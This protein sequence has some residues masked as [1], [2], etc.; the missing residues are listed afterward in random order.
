MQVCLSGPGLGDAGTLVQQ[1]DE[2][3]PVLSRRDV[4][5]LT[6]GEHGCEVQTDDEPAE[7]D[8]A[9]TP[10]KVLCTDMRLHMRLDMRLDV[11]LKKCPVCQRRSC[12]AHRWQRSVATVSGDSQR[13]QQVATVSGDGQES[14]RFRRKRRVV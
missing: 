14:V 4:I 8:A 5:T 7:A 11:C 10:T 3:T 6:T 13:Q 12:A 1:S 9:S 2:A